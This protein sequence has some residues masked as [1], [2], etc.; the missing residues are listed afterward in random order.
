ML[1]R[2]WNYVKGYVII[3]VEGYFLEKFV[4]ICTRRQIFLW[5][6]KKRK[7][8]TMSMKVSIKGFKM[9]RPIA[10]KTGCR[11]RIQGR[12]GVPFVLY[13]YK[14]RKTFIAGA[15]LFI[16][17]FYFMSSFIWSIEITGNEK[18]EAGAIMDRVYQLGVK[19][20]VLKYRIDPQDIASNLMFDINELS[21]VSVVIKGTK[22]KIEVAEGVE[23]PQLVDKNTPCDIVAT[24]DGVIKSIIVKSGLEAVKVGET[25]KKG[26]VLISGTVPVKNQEDSPRVLHAIGDVIARTWYDAK[27]PVETKL[28]E[29]NRTGNQKDNLSLVLFS[30]KID[31]F[32]TSSPYDEYD[33]ASIEKNLSIGEDLVL[34]FGIVIERYYENN[35]IEKEISLDEAKKIAA[36]NAYKKAAANLPKAA[37]VVETSVNFIENEDGLLIAEAIIECLENIGYEREIG[38]N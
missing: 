13:R 33:K 29:K 35:I 14:K 11:V 25:V 34:P 28:I 36:N 4:N 22:V 26:Q 23:R 8:S 24:K 19:P 10:K 15:V 32:H 21:W 3:I 30:K 12:R 6:V 38:G 18:L 9:L 37:R 17:L 2:L 1:L 7:N 31:L 5:D 16:F 20:G 27:E